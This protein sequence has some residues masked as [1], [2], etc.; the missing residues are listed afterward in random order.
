MDEIQEESQPYLS[1]VNDLDVLIK[2][3]ERKTFSKF[4][5]YRKDGKFGQNG[6]CPMSVRMILHRKCSHVFFISASCFLFGKLMHL[7]QAVCVTVS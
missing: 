1:N 5:S 4:M 7:D 6:G 2:D 3:Y